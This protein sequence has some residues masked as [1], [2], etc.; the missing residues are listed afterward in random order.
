[1]TM[2]KETYSAKAS[3]ILDVAEAHMRKGGFDAVSFR[4]LAA[5]VGVKS[6]S[7]HYYFPQKADLGKAVV[8]RYKE[9]VVAALGDPFDNRTPI[10]KLKQLF[11]VYSTALRDGDSVC[12][13]CMLGAEARYLP[14]DVAAEVRL[15]FESMTNW[16]RD[17]LAT[18]LPKTKAT[19]TATHIISALQGAMVLSVALGDENHLKNSQKMLMRFVKNELKS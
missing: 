19:A 18:D 5:A 11:V 9:R 3:E 12:L 14:A 15:F 4:D 17:A 16:T 8:A 13:C 2:K 1:M 7:V 10:A 6:A